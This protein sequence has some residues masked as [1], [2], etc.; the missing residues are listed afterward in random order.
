ME[1]W[2]DF[3]DPEV[4]TSIS[5]DPL[6]TDGVEDAVRAASEI[7][8]LLTGYRIHPAGAT[9]QD[10][11]LRA[12]PLL[13]LTPAYRPVTEIHSIATVGADCTADVDI[14][15]QFCLIGNDIKRVANSQAATRNAVLCNFC[16][17]THDHIRLSYSF[18]STVG[19]SAVRAVTTFARQLWLA[20]H[21]ESGE[22]M[23]PERI[24]SLNREGLSY[25]FIDPMTFLDQGRTGIPTVD[26]FLAA[27]NS[28]KA[29][30]P[31]AVYIPEAPPGVVRR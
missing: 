19:R 10:F 4:I 27:V 14:S 25:S 7:L 30:V 24:T 6:V 18:G 9:T 22:C 5:G 1:P 15:D 21:P 16:S 26:T 12:V 17:Q 11:T 23:L 20:D 8:T 31:S 29:K 2:I 13:R 3:C 28:P